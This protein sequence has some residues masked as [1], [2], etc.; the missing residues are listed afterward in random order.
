MLI[1]T[2]SNYF[3]TEHFVPH[4]PKQPSQ[5]KLTFIPTAAEVEKGD[6]QWLRDDRQALVNAG[7]QVSDFTVTGKTK[8]EVKTMLESTDFVFV[9]GGNTFYLLQEMRKSGFAEL[10]AEYVKKGVVYGGS[11]AGS[12]VTGPD[13]SLVKELDD[14]SLAPELTDYK[15]LNL[16]DVSVL[17]HWGS[18]HFQKRYRK[19]MISE[20]KTG[21]KI[22]LLTDDQYLLVKDNKFT[23]ET[24]TP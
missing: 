18:E 7:F 19:V 21:L 9:A 2:S 1:L 4:L 8:V 13:I 5:M 24:I 6:L 23:I 14:A 15:G 17:P 20:Y 22:I 11:S 16:V 10:I 3:V 12:V